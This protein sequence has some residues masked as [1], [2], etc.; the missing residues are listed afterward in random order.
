MQNKE[1]KAYQALSKESNALV[2]ELFNK[3]GKKL[4]IYAKNR[5]N[6]N[7]DD[8][9]HLVYKT[10]YQV[11][12]TYEKY[13][14]ENEDKFASFVFRVFVNFLRNHYRDNKKL[15]D[16]F[17]L[18]YVDE[19]VLRNTKSPDIK[20][21]IANTKMQALNSVLETLEDWQRILLLM[22]SEGHPYSEIA[23]YIDKPEEQLKV[24][25]Q[26]LKK[27]ISKSIHDRL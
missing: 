11:I 3:Y 22:R 21:E 4:F 10:L 15:S 14:F 2:S 20:P 13:K 7:E 5:W 12:K 17:N 24:Y 9:W 26:R 8:A 23:K 6:L 27:Q 16:E 1:S 18:V 19:T 25:Y